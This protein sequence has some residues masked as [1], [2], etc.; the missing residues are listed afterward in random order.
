MALDEKEKAA[1]LIGDMSGMEINVA[2]EFTDGDDDYEDDTGLTQTSAEL[3]RS[4]YFTPGSPD[5]NDF[6]V[7]PPES[8]ADY[9][10]KGH[11]VRNDIYLQFV[12]PDISLARTNNACFDK[13][14]HLPEVSGYE[15]KK[16]TRLPFVLKHGPRLSDSG[17][18]K[19]ITMITRSVITQ[20]VSM[21]GLLNITLSTG[22]SATCIF[23]LESL[24]GHT[25]SETDI[26]EGESGILK[27]TYEI[28]GET[29]TYHG[30]G[31]VRVVAHDIEND[32]IVSVP[33]QVALGARFQILAHSLKIISDE[34]GRH[35]RR[36]L[37]D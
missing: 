5:W 20:S 27:M 11:A 33:L 6:H 25:F 9:Q 37:T 17:G 16:A 26:S 4:R 13:F 19:G 30:P 22:C 35:T 29:Y 28:E 7:Y 34:M 24:A 21:S 3:V 31:K 12:N 18:G 2:E 1:D 14:K 10:E 23:C 32:T 36:V 8:I 15:T